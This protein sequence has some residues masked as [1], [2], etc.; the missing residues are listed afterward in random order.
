MGGSSPEPDDPPLDPSS[1]HFT[2]FDPSPQRQSVSD[3][4]P[5]E[6]GTDGGPRLPG[7]RT[8]LTLPRSV[9][10]PS[11]RPG[12]EWSVVDRHGQSHRPMLQ[13]WEAANFD[14]EDT[15]QWGEVGQTVES[16]HRRGLRLALLSLAV[17][18]PLGAVVVWQSAPRTVPEAP[19]ARPATRPAAVPA[20]SEH[21]R[22]AAFVAEAFLATSTLEARASLVRHPEITRA[23]MEAWHTPEHP[24]RPLKVL[25]FHERWAEESVGKNTFL[26]LYMEMADFT[27]RAIALE[28]A[29][30]GGFKIDWE[31]FEGWSPLPWTRFL[32][33]EPSAAMEFR[34]MVQRDTYHNFG[35]ADPDAWLSFKLTD[36][37]DLA[38]C[39]GY[40]PVTSEAGFTL[41]RLLRRQTQQGELQIKAIVRLRF[42]EGR[43]GHQQVLIESVVQ[44][45]WLKPD[46]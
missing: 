41:S 12:E 23:R 26:L 45:G 21:A 10:L 33:E 27:T 31:S 34:V 32:A 38:H 30:E 20:T 24:L 39:W 44:D 43:S 40:C 22:Q 14:P 25:H 4:A 8:P 19:A 13:P 29:P 3:P 37:A 2:M 42:E 15:D 9:P 36:P 16:R 17:A 18:L 1:S 46:P 5:W 11:L 6:D 28:R 35:Y 7:P